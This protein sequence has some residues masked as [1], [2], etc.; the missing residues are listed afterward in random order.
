MHEKLA[1]RISSE[2]KADL[3]NIWVY[4][5]YKWSKEQADSYYSEIISQ[6]EFLRSNYHSG[7][8]AEN[9]RPGYRV[10]VIKSHIIFYSLIENRE[11]VVIRILHQ[12]VHLENWLD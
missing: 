12:S 8:S 4:T 10:S 7:K 2:A 3:E 11:L 6:I 5:F 9:I 1:L